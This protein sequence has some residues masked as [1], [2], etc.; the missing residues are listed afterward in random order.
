MTFKSVYKISP[1]YLSKRF[2]LCGNP[3][4]EGVQTRAAKQNKLRVPRTRNKFDT[5]SFLNNG[6]KV[7]N[8]L[9]N[10]LRQIKSLVSFKSKIKSHFFDV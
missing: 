5:K 1:P 9:P 2:V 3:D 6:T 8:D 10:E 4:D 7:W